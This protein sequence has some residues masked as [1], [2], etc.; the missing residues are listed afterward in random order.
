MRIT[1]KSNVVI[2]LDKTVAQHRKKNQCND[3]AKQ[4]ANKDQIY[5]SREVEQP[6]QSIGTGGIFRNRPR[7][8]INSPTQLRLFCFWSAFSHCPQFARY[9]SISSFGNCPNAS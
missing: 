9:R 8:D 7:R 4:D 6:L 3:E 5:R 1:I 2:P